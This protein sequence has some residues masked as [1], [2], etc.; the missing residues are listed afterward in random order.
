M[1]KITL[2]RER[3]DGKYIKSPK[4][5]PPRPNDHAGS[6]PPF[7]IFAS[8]KS[9]REYKRSQKLYAH[10]KQYPISIQEPKYSWQLD[11]SRQDPEF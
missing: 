2:G 5:K 4:I 7:H 3:K 11:H 10:H 6:G 8:T 9:F 1:G